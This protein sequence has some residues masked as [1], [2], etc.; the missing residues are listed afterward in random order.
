[1]AYEICHGINVNIKTKSDLEPSYNLQIETV[2]YVNVFNKVN[3]NYNY[4]D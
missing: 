1:M 2:G 4:I 3:M